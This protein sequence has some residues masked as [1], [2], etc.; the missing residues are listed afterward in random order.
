MGSMQTFAEALIAGTR[1][2]YRRQRERLAR[3]AP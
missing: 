1:G 2:A 3:Q